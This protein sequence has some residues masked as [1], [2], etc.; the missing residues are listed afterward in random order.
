VQQ[1]V[2]QAGNAEE[3]VAPAEAGEPAAVEEAAGA[4]VDA[5]EEAPGTAESPAIDPVGES[6]TIK[7]SGAPNSRRTGGKRFV[8]GVRCGVRDITVLYL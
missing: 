3:G 2:D 8:K 4:D 7:D 6:D 5:V 1:E